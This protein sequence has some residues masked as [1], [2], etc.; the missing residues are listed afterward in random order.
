ME[1]YLFS[2]YL[3]PGHFQVYQK[4]GQERTCTVVMS[5]IGDNGVGLTACQVKRYRVGAGKD[6]RLPLEE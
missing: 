1:L 5:A 3:L 2:S 6:T 4:Q